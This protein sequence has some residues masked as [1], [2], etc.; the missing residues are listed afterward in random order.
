MA[1]PQAP[2]IGR[3]LQ[4]ARQMHVEQPATQRDEACLSD[5]GPPL[6]PFP[7][8]TDGAIRADRNSANGGIADQL[9]GRIGRR[10][11]FGTYR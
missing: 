5:P 2:C 9:P 8:P 6:P 7:G 10:P 1:D 3:R 11:P 4:V